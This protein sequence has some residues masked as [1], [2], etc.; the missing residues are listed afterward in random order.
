MLLILNDGSTEPLV[1]EILNKYS[2]EPKI[3]VINLETNVG[4]ASTLNHGIQR[5]LELEGI[6]Y[7]ARMDADDLSLPH[8]LECQIKYL[9]RNP[10]IDILGTSVL[11]FGDK[12]D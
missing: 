7:I 1:N 3:Q 11:L 2:K 12:K 9:E 6:K 4:L 8:R 10:S 5:A